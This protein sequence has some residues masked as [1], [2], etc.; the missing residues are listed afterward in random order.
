MKAYDKK[1]QDRKN[2]AF[3]LKEARNLLEYSDLAWLCTLHHSEHFGRLRLERHYLGFQDTYDEYKR[4]YLAAD[5]STILINRTDTGVLKMH[6]RQ[7]GVD[8][9]ALVDESYLDGVVGVYGRDAE[10]QQKRAIVMREALPVM[11]HANLTHLIT[12]HDNEGHG[13]ERMERV[14]LR[15]QRDYNRFKRNYLSVGACTVSDALSKKLKADL[16]GIGLD[17]DALVERILD[18]YKK[19]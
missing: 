17:Y 8:Y 2:R 1:A 9:D 14:F 13:K 5:D 6:L 7:F 11:E 10:L 19:E 18:G 15:F 4:R 3:I 12:L 16:R